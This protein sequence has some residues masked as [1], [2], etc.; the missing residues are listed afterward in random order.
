MKMSIAMLFDPETRPSAVRRPADPVEIKASRLLC[1]AP[2]SELRQNVRCQV[3]EGRLLLVGNVTTF[4]L[5]Q[6]AQEIVREVPGVER[7]TNEIKV[8]R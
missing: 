1:T 6:T 5:K 2:Y 3:S 8:A 7:I 4:Y